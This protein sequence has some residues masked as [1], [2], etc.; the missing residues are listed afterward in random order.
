MLAEKEGRAEAF[1]KAED[2]FQRSCACAAGGGED[3]EGE[4]RASAAEVSARHRKRSP[5]LR[6]F[7]GCVFPYLP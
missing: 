2:R 3:E 5:E 1:V 7:L 6:R 4:E